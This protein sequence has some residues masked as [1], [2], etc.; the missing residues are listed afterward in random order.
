VALINARELC[1][2]STFC[3]ISVFVVFFVF[4]ERKQKRSVH[5]NCTRRLFGRRVCGIVIEINVTK[6]ENWSETRS[7]S[8]DAAVEIVAELRPRQYVLEV[9]GREGDGDVVMWTL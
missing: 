3:F 9:V 7:L 4:S 5:L 6:S 8:C 1:C 2:F